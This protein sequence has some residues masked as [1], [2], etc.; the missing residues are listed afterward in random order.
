MFFFPLLGS[1][2]PD[3]DLGTLKELILVCFHAILQAEV[4]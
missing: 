2:I 3:L 1:A 4:Y